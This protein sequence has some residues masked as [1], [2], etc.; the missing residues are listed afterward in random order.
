[1]ATEVAR[2]AGITAYANH[3][4]RM[5]VAPDRT[6]IA[7]DTA[8]VIQARLVSWNGVVDEVVIR[9]ITAND[10]L[11]EIQALIAAAAPGTGI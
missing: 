2:Y 6:C 9:G 1:M 11:A 8:E 4:A 5:G 7:A 10:T 3:F